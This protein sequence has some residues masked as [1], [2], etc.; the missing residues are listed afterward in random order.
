[1]ADY[2]RAT[3]WVNDRFKEFLIIHRKWKEAQFRK[4]SRSS[5]LSLEDKIIDYMK[6]HGDRITLTQLNDDITGSSDA[7]KR[8]MESMADLGKVKQYTEGRTRGWRLPQGAE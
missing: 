2:E 7:K 6:R 8:T 3:T 1:M 4:I 5:G